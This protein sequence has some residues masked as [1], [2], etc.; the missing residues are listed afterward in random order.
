LISGLVWLLAMAFWLG[1][2]RYNVVFGLETRALRRE[3]NIHSR[4]IKLS[5]YALTFMDILARAPNTMLMQQK[6][7]Q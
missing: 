1:Y 6:T 5:Q 4:A 3:N 7:Q 2:E